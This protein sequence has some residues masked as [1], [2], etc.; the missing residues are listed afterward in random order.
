MVFNG[1]TKK[2]TSALKGIAIL[3]I[4]CHNFF[5]HLSPSPGENEFLFSPNTVHTFFQMLGDQPVEFINLIFS[6]LG[7]FGVQVFI[8]LSGYGLALSMLKHEKDWTTFMVDRLKKLYPL[9]LTGIIV[10]LLYKIVGQKMLFGHAEW[11]EVKYKLLFVSNII[12]NSGL[13]LNGPWW[14]FGLIFE[15][16]LLFPLLYKLIKRFDW[17]AF[18]A[19]CVFSYCLIFL[20]RN[21]FNLYQGEILM[22]NAPGHLPEFCFGIL[23]AFHKGVKIH[24]AWLLLAIAVFCLGNFYAAFYPFTFLAVSVIA[25]FIYQGMKSL[26]HRKGCLVKTAVYFGELSMVMFAVHG[27]FRDPFLNINN[28]GDNFGS[29]LLAFLLFFLTILIVS[30]GAKKVY[31]WLTSAFA[32]IKVRES[33]AT[34]I[35]GIVLQVA[36][37]V[38]FA[39]VIAFY[40][41]QNCKT[42]EKE[43]ENYEIK[44]TEISASSDVEYASFAKVEFDM[45]PVILKI[46]GS[47]DL[48]SLDS[49]SRLPIIVI[50]VAGVLWD[51][52]IIPEDFNTSEFKRF[53]FSYE[54]RCPLNKNLKG[55][56]LKVYFWNNS[57]CSFEA[58]D[59]DISVKY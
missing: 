36:F 51:K 5:H 53:D 47:F 52:I 56:M 35:I 17:K 59:I 30:L 41:M 15:L 54:Y 25:L 10:L 2:D 20:F 9:L 37:G 57:R 50:D 8:L 12:P 42:P 45:K 23:L 4:V 33:Q 34:R 11:I 1:L 19:I 58:K 22:M 13:S 38:F 39:Y 14:F 43:I 31:D 27:F 55:K 28:I 6:Y 32:R 3:C 49:V 16:Y 29:H 26:P 44:P 46:E 48:M 18:A 21:V 40:V 24:P 7:H